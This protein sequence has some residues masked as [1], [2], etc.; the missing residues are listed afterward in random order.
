VRLL[1]VCVSARARVCLCVCV[2]SRRYFVS[3]ALAVRV[4]EGISS[5]LDPDIKLR[6]LATQIFA[7]LRVE[8]GSQPSFIVA[9]AN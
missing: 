5:R 2:F 6:P 8:V 9:F 1:R 7:Q 4:M 3:V